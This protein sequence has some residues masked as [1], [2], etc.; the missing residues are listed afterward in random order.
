[1]SDKPPVLV[2]DGD[3]AVCEF[4]LKALRVNGYPAVAAA[5]ADGA[6]VLL[7]SRD[8]AVLVVDVFLK[9]VN[10]VELLKQTRVSFPGT[11]VMLMG[12]DTPTY[13]L[14][15]A[16]KEGAFDFIEKPLDVDY[17]LQVLHKAVAHW[18]LTR[19][20]QALRRVRDLQTPHP[21]GDMVAASPPM[22]DV[23][24]T[25]E[26]VAPTDLTVLVEGE[27]G[28]GKELVA[29]RIHTSSPRHDRTFVAVNCGAIQE[30]LLESELFGHVKGAFTG[31]TKDH[32]GLFSVADRG[33]LFLD[34][35]GEMN[36]D[37]QVK[38]LRVL[39]RSEFR[40]VG[41]TKQVTVDVRVVAATNKQLSEEVKAGRFREDLY[42]RLNVIHIEVPPLRK[43]RED[44]PALVQAFLDSHHRKGLPKRTVSADAL[45]VLQSYPWPGNVRELRNI[46]ERSMILCHGEE[47]TAQ[48][49]PA[50]LRPGGDHS[51]SPE[52]PG[53][54]VVDAS[55][56]TPLADVE[57]R[58]ILRVLEANAG[59]KVRSAKVLGINVKTLYNKLKSYEA[60]GL[61]P[62]DS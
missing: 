41:D 54:S 49:L 17:F 39:E 15:G 38:L 22:L 9:G 21:T 33:T 47:I 19:E 24:K 14:V 60:A 23:I 48:D 40:R 30:S 36:L 32:D 18:R 53:A 50:L 35:I 8:V 6:L 1:M 52:F 37:L 31:A 27:S 34:E 10:G 57:R 42:Y 58:H 44:V 29:N 11:Q 2:V 16:M 46:I 5:D 26:L 55:V 28:V 62:G 7:E 4:L 3:E 25:V 43:R 20:N 56:E 12:R 59:N 61:L 45:A 13:T 51:Q